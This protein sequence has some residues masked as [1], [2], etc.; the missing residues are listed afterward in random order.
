MIVN[1]SQKLIRIDNA[2][3]AFPHL[4][5]PWGQE[6]KTYSVEALMNP[7]DPVHQQ[8]Y[9]EFQQMT[10]KVLQENGKGDLNPDYLIPVKSGEQKNIE[11]QQKGKAPRP[12]LVG[13]W[14]LYAA[15]G[16][17]PP[18]VFDQHR[19]PVGPEQSANFFGGCVCNVIVNLY[20]RKV[21][22]NPGVS[23]GLKVVQLVNNVGV[24]RF[25]GGGGQIANPE[26]YLPEVGQG[27][28]APLTSA[29]GN[30]GPAS[31]LPPTQG[32]D[33]M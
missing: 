19:Q 26:Q 17:N 3:I 28:P 23:A 33:W 21:P 6:N 31:T 12:E 27:A 32:D 30:V 7:K 15:D 16:R 20:W 24:E 29:P 14:V 2:I 1:E 9:R 5:E 11:L 4:F 10:A 18:A 8:I 13:K 22:T 25:A